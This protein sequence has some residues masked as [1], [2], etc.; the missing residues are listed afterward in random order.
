[1]SS[2][3]K[4]VLPVLFV[5]GILFISCRKDCYLNHNG[6]IT[7]VPRY[8]S[9]DEFKQGIIKVV[10]MAQQYNVVAYL[11]TLPNGWPNV[12][13]RKVSLAQLGSVILEKLQGGQTESAVNDVFHFD[14]S[15]FSLI[16]YLKKA[17]MVNN[18]S[19]Q[20]MINIFSEIPLPPVAMM[21]YDPPLKIAINPVNCCD[22]DFKVRVTWVYKPEC[23]NS[24]TKLTGYKDVKN[25]DKGAVY[26][27]DPE[28]TQ[29]DCGGT[30]SYTIDAPANGQYASSINKYGNVSFTPVTAG[31]FKI[32][33]TY[34]CPCGA[35]ISKT[36]SIT[37]S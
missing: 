26:R 37:A 15:T 11:D 25:G 14:G 8:S 22:P 12:N 18:I 29:C 30:W 10:N 21:Y 32:T 36:I 3:I 17:E 33:I 7:Y 19:P 24:V 13:G 16:S 9:V 1:M 34:K 27:L 31:T 20:T 35:V 2:L 6:E 23:G 4:K 5:L 28:L